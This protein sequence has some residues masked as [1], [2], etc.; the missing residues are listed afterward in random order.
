M[1]S[2][3]QSHLHS[4]CSLAYLIDTVHEMHPTPEGDAQAQNVAYFQ[5]YR[6][7]SSFI[8]KAM[9]IDAAAFLQQSVCAFRRMGTFSIANG[10]SVISS[11]RTITVGWDCND[12]LTKCMGQAT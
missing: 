12:L 5:F 3:L 7:N 8:E 1:Q 11:P 10:F 4:I 9:S 6:T 2:Y